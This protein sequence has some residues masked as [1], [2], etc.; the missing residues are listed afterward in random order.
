MSGSPE[1]RG[2]VT[3]DG[4]HIPSA[5]SVR[6]C[7]ALAS[8]S[9]PT[10]PGRCPGVE[11]PQIQAHHPPGTGLLRLGAVPDLPDLPDPLARP[12]RPAAGPGHP[13][14]LKTSKH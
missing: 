3:N 2:P 10:L 11:C 6:Q 8:R 1:T 4:P 9:S 13:R 12:R 14:C 7:K 5:S